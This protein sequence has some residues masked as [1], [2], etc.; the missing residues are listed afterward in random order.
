MIAA[1]PLSGCPLVKPA[2]QNRRWPSEGKSNTIGSTVG[3]IMNHWGVSPC[4]TNPPVAKAD[5]RNDTNTQ[6]NATESYPHPP[7]PPRPPGVANVGP[8]TAIATH[9]Q[10]HRTIV[11][12]TVATSLMHQDPTSRRCGHAR[13]RSTPTPRAMH[14]QHTEPGPSCCVPFGYPHVHNVTPS[15]NT[16]QECSHS[17]ANTLG[18]SP[19]YGEDTPDRRPVQREEEGGGY[20]SKEFCA[21]TDLCPL[22]SPRVAL[23][24]VCLLRHPDNGN[25][26]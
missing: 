9:T 8:T 7:N 11:P 14:K 15:Y 6:R 19:P 4:Y 1:S 13:R 17:S 10:P 23:V 18:T 12:R 3:V 21:N 22:A 20:I 25:T 16:R 5:H 2:T 24:G 26:R